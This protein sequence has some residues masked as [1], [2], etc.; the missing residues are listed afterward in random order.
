MIYQRGASNEHHLYEND[1]KLGKKQWNKKILLL[2]HTFESDLLVNFKREFHQLWTKFY[3]YKG[4]MM[5]NK[6][7]MITSLGNPLLNDL[8]VHKKPSGSLLTR[9]EIA[10]SEN[11]QEL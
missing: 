10:S 6:H 4:S 7:L 3:V 11:D 9:M 8:L 5:K 1:N 2:S